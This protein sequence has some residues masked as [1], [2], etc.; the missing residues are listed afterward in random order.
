[1]VL[2]LIQ[3]SPTSFS[4]NKGERW[5]FYHQINWSRAFFPSPSCDRL[6]TSSIHGGC[7]II[8]LSTDPSS[9][10]HRTPGMPCWFA[11]LLCECFLQQSSSYLLQ[12]STTRTGKKCPCISQ[13]IKKKH[14]LLH[15]FFKIFQH[16]TSLRVFFGVVRSELN[17]AIMHSCII[18]DTLSNYFS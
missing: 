8:N 11:I 9:H 17:D 12:K 3:N 14:G 7:Y 6:Y 16:Y 10:Q 4:K 18:P 15:N 1:M 13:G 5:L 2:L